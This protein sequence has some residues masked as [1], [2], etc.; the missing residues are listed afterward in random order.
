VFGR[1]ELASFESRR[2]VEGSR[3]AY[4]FPTAGRK[5]AGRKTGIRFGHLPA[6]IFLPQFSC[7]FLRSSRFPAACCYGARGFRAGEFSIRPFLCP[8]FLCLRFAASRLPIDA[9]AELL[10]RAGFHGRFEP[11][12]NV[13]FLRKPLDLGDEILR[14]RRPELQS[15]DVQQSLTSALV[16]AHGARLRLPLQDLL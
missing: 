8:T 14:K 13:S 15:Q 5:T 6:M 7:Q 9:R 4:R 12:G 3:Q 11:T 16:P 2:A 1:F 10:Q